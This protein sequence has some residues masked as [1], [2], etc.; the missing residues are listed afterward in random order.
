MPSFTGASCTQ[1]Q[2]LL[3]GANALGSAT[4]DLLSAAAGS[5][6]NARNSGSVPLDGS[7]LVARVS[8]SPASATLLA[9]SALSLGVGGGSNGLFSSTS[10]SVSVSFAY[11]NG[12]TASVF[13]LQLALGALVGCVLTCA[14][15]V[16]KYANRSAAVSY[17]PASVP[18]TM[19][20]SMLYST[21][22][23]QGAITG[24]SVQVCVCVCSRLHVC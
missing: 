9:T 14:A 6:L 11:I 5:A 19:V 12:S 24:F 21:P 1:R 17:T 13:L 10:V 18:S 16:L 2:S 3:L 23:A 15:R 4:L 20:S 22:S 7:D 8:L